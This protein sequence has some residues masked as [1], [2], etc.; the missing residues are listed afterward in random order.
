MGFLRQRYWSGVPLPSPDKELALV[1]TCIIALVIQP[2][3]EL[4]PGTPILQLREPRCH[5]MRAVTFP[6]P[7]RLSEMELG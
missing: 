1:K 7:H 5:E 2:P 6:G 4:H 3:P